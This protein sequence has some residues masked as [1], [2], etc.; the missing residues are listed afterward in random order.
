LVKNDKIGLRCAELRAR[1]NL[2]GVAV[3]SLLSVIP[4][5]LAGCATLTGASTAN[6]CP[7]GAAS[8]TQATEVSL[9]FAT[10]RASIEDKQS[11]IDF[12]LDRSYSLTFGQL[13][14]SVPPTSAR[15][16]GSIDAD[17][18]VTGARVFDDRA[19]FVQALRAEIDRRNVRGR[20]ASPLIFVHGYAESF[21]RTAYRNAQIVIDGGLNVIPIL[22]S[23][24]SRN[25][26]LDYAYDRESATFSRDALQDVISAAYE[27]NRSKPPD[28][29]AHSMGNWIAIE[30]A[31]GLP[32]ASSGPRR[33]IGA[34]VLASPDVDI[35]VFGK[36]LPRA[37]AGADTT[38]LMTSRNDV[39]LGLSQFLAHGVP[40][41]G[42]ASP[43][44][45]S[46]H[47]VG[48]SAHFAVLDMDGPT[49]DGCSPFDHHCAE[50]TPAMLE[51]VSA[52]LNKG[53]SE[54][55]AAKQ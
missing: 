36:D 9:F 11:Q 51:V 34:M 18:R 42:N 17:F 43:Q 22:F 10:N 4:F 27:A 44:E 5:F 53:N 2:E 46:S 32:G 29:F 39:L 1:L 50:T 12:S 13:V 15:A 28:V 7:P 54:R 26:P 20:L 55:A 19:N 49:G 6:R 48:S 41:A 8:C 33:K 47:R 38:L 25:S 16:V 3:L 23:W 40:R 52:F 14:I 45:L 24:P 31:A 37:I 35:D 30:A 21:R